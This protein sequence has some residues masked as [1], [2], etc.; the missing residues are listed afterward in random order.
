MVNYV[1]RRLGWLVIV[2][3]AVTFISY[4]IFFL[5]PP[6]DPALRFAGK[7]PTPESTASGAW[8]SPMTGFTGPSRNWAL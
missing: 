8:R 7:N 1:A 6:G 4:A 2:M 5:L 3:L